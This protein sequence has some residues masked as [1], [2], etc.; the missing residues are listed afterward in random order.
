VL[1]Q[2]DRQVV[3]TR[4]ENKDTEEDRSKMAEL[5][6][7]QQLAA[8]A[9]RMKKAKI[10][11]ENDEAA[12]G[13]A[14]RFKISEVFSDGS[15]GKDYSLLMLDTAGLYDLADT[16]FEECFEDEIYAHLWTVA[17]GGRRYS[18]P[19]SGMG[20]GKHECSGDNAETRVPLHR[21]ALKVGAQGSFE[22]QSGVFKFT[23]EDVY[24]PPSG[25]AASFPTISAIA[26]VQYSADKKA[27]FLSPDKVAAAAAFRADYE[28]YAAGFNSWERDRQCRRGGYKLAKPKPQ[29]WGN[30][31][32]NPKASAF[33]EHL[34]SCSTRAGLSRTPGHTCYSTPCSRAPRPRPPCATGL[35]KRRRT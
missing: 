6:T 31:M 16:V 29:D 5:A 23:L 2:R 14:L 21:L 4:G 18:G 25:D 26:T 22:G 20:M 28:T 8:E 3:E 17:I 13:K 24:D 33:K 7:A 10:K 30:H 32:G 35:S 27:D 34:I 15:Y 11:P 1:L 19:F 12:S 9:P